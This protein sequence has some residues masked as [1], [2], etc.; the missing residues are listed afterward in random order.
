M[1]NRKSSREEETVALNRD[2]LDKDQRVTTVQTI[3]L[4]YCHLFLLISEGGRFPLFL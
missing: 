2:A 3:D 4:I 1:V